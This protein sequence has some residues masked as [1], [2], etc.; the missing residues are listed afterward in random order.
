MRTHSVPVHRRH[1][2][3]GTRRVIERINDESGDAVFDQ[4]RHRAAAE[5]DHR[6]SAGHRLY[7]DKPEWLRPADREQQRSGIP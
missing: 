4:F 6:S 3:Y 7:D 5:G 1:A 2:G